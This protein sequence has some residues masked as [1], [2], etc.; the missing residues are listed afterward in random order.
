MGISSS[1]EAKFVFNEYKSA[2]EWFKKLSSDEN[3]FEYYLTELSF[4]KVRIGDF[5][6]K[7]VV[8]LNS[9]NRNYFYEKWFLMKLLKGVSDD[10]IQP[11][12][13]DYFEWVK[14]INAKY[15]CAIEWSAT[16]EHGL[17][18]HIVWDYDGKVIFKES[19]K[20]TFETDEHTNPDF[21]KQNIETLLLK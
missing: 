12:D 21:N 2:L 11:N 10:E 15:K 17:Q 8:F 13:D 1:I 18:D 5:D 14:E 4:K 6:N 16:S 9:S 7:F 19:D 20:W 3:I